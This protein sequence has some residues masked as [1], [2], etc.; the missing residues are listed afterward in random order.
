M[1]SLLILLYYWYWYYPEDLATRSPSDSDFNPF[2]ALAVIA[3]VIAIVVLFC[4][5]GWLYEKYFLIPRG[6]MFT[7]SDK[8]IFKIVPYNPKQVA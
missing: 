4:Y 8:N 7:R 2:I 1:K 5:C 6:K 3:A